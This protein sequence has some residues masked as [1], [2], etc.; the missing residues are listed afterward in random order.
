M[1]SRYVLV[2]EKE[3]VTFEK[4]WQLPYGYVN[5]PI[6]FNPAEAGQWL[7]NIVELGENPDQW[8]ISK[9]NEFNNEFGTY[10]F[11]QPQEFLL[12]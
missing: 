4:K 1:K 12:K 2:N 8:Y 7:D 9:I 3:K 5:S 10:R 6:T 11:G